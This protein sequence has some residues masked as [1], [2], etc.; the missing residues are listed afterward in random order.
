VIYVFTIQ[1]VH[2]LLLAFYNVFFFI[3]ISIAVH[4]IDS[5]STV[6]LIGQPAKPS[7]EEEFLRMHARKTISELVKLKEDVVFAVCAEVVRIVD[8]ID[9]W[10]PACKC[11]KAVVPDAGSYFCS[12]CAKH[13][14]NVVP[15]YFFACLI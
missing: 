10:Y 9:W 5:D 4:G 11:H 8:G 7:F 3:G 13:V 15:R 2:V 1:F 14:F 6:P 12:S